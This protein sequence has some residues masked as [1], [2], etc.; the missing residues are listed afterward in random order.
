MASSVSM[1]LECFLPPLGFW[2]LEPSRN[3]E[4]LQALNA[5]SAYRDLV[6]VL[7]YHR[8]SRENAQSI[9]K[10]G[11]RDGAG[12]YLTNEIWKGVWISNRP[13]DSNEGAEGDALL[14]IRIPESEVTPFEW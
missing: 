5:C 8:T 7:Y 14:E 1:R 4:A 3:D 10:N 11:F 9:L 13:L 6:S 2:I 12:K